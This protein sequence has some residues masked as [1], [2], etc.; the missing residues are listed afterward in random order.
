MPIDGNFNVTNINTKAATVAIAT[1]A[2][3][4]ITAAN[5]VAVNMQ[6]FTGGNL[7]YISNSG[8][9]T[10]SIAILVADSVTGTFLPANA[11]GADHSTMA[12]VA[13]I[14]TTASTSSAYSVNGIMANAVKFVPTVT[15]TL[16]YTLTFT[17]SR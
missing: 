17:P 8:T 2:S 3:A 14:V 15:G 6:N 7:S 5:S 13:P 11:Q 10:L 1:G 9:G 12:A 4:S 16:N